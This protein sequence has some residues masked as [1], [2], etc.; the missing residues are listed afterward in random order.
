MKKLAIALFLL[1]ALAP[2]VFAMASPIHTP[3]NMDSITP[4][5]IFPGSTITIKGSGFALTTQEECLAP[6]KPWPE[7]IFP[8]SATTEITALKDV[9]PEVYGY[10]PS[11]NFIIVS[12]TPDTIVARAPAQITT[13]NGPYGITLYNNTSDGRSGVSNGEI[14]ITVTGAL[15][16]RQ[17]VCTSKSNCV[18]GD[19]TQSTVSPTPSPS[20]TPSAVTSFVKSIIEFFRALLFPVSKAQ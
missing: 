11:F 1:T 19:E 3:Q 8:C 14:A 9:G 2:P 5:V 20:Q 10:R 6:D 4:L 17:K 15:N 13:G 16:L 18:T 7:G 12:L